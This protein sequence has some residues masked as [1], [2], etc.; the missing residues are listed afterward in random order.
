MVVLMGNSG[1]L[2]GNIIN[3]TFFG[4]PPLILPVTQDEVPHRF[5]CGTEEVVPCSFLELIQRHAGGKS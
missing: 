3:G 2:N 5:G 1:G 4:T